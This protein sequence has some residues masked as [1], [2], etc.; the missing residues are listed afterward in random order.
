MFI[1]LQKVT[2]RLFA[3][4]CWQLAENLWRLC[5]QPRS[6]VPGGNR[7]NIIRARPSDEDLK[8]H[9]S[10]HHLS[11]GLLNEVS[12]KKHLDDKLAC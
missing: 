8:K 7:S 1:W 3:Q 4:G 5:F 11:V 9:G 2:A 6:S 12:G 10:K